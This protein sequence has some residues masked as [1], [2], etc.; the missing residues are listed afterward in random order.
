MR[1]AQ[2][3]PKEGFHPSLTLHSGAELFVGGIWMTCRVNT[4]SP[5]AQNGVKRPKGVVRF[6]I[7]TCCKSIFSNANFA[8]GIGMG[9]LVKVLRVTL[10]S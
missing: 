10:G 5:D 3:F 4:K 6:A 1:R 2:A 7:P 8:K 9:Q